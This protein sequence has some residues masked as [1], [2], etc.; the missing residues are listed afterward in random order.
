M[1][2]RTKPKRWDEDPAV[3][4]LLKPLHDH[5]DSIGARFVNEW[6]GPAHATLKGQPA[7]VFIMYRTSVRCY[8]IQIHSDM[9]GWEVWSPVSDNIKIEDTLAAIV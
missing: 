1:T 5:L 8:I 9:H 6:D 7:S 4:E 2:G 3:T